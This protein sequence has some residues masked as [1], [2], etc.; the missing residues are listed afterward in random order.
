[1]EKGVKLKRYK[2]EDKMKKIEFMREE[3]WKNKENCV[4]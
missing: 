3:E 4:L 1:M 2:E